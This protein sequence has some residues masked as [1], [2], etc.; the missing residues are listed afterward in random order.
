MPETKPD[1]TTAVID[2]S[3]QPATPSH[4][5]SAGGDMAREIGQRDEAKTAEGGDPLPTSVD[6]RDK[7]ADG[8]LPTPRQ[9]RR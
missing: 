2:E 4:Q 1:E 6:K 5:G 8:D 3:Q 7:P 9:T